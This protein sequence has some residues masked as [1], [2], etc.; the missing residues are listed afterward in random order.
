MTYKACHFPANDRVRE[1]AKARAAVAAKDEV[2]I[3]PKMLVVPVLAHRQTETVLKASSEELQGRRDCLSGPFFE[4]LVNPWRSFLG[5]KVD[6]IGPTASAID[7]GPTLTRQKR[8]K[9]ETAVS[10]RL[11]LL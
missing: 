11:D 10:R 6:G 3:H 9:V 2:R 4:K 8:P 7:S 1:V 5:A